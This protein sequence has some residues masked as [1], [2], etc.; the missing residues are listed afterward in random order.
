MTKEERLQALNDWSKNTLLQTLHIHFTD[1]GE[2]FLV[3][4]MP[5]TPLVHQPLGMLHGGASAALAESLGSSLSNIVIDQ[6]V[7]AAVGTHISCNHLKSKRS[8]ILT[9]KAQLIRKG[10]TQ[11]FTEIEIRDEKGD[12]IC[13][14]TMTNV[15]INVR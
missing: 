15:L 14:A 7:N 5:V 4:T 2:D 13:H 11:H 3:A 10:R 8:G 6:S 12:L 9:G 1:V